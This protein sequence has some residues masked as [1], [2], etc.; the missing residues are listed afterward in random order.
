M[1]PRVGHPATA[2]MWLPWG[3][4]VFSLD[5]PLANEEA[6]EHAP[7]ATFTQKL[8]EDGGRWAIGLLGQVVHRLAADRGGGVVRLDPGADLLGPL[9]PCGYRWALPGELPSQP[10]RMPPGARP[11]PRRARAP[12]A[13]PPGPRK[14]PR[15]PGPLPATA[16]PAVGIDPVW[17]VAAVSRAYAAGPA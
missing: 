14:P 9:G 1:R 12:R 16:G 4:T 17:G 7:T 11:P 13:P 15:P 3:R 8:R 6:S 2:T 5:Q 10:G